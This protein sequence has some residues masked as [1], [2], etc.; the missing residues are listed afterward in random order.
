MKASRRLTLEIKKD[1][2]QNCKLADKR[3]LRQRRPYCKADSPTIRNGHC[4]P[5]KPIKAKPSNGKVSRNKK[6]ERARA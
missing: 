4:I 3:T 6:Q 2:C 1:Q 5:F